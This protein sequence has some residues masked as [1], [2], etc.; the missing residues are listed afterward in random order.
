MDSDST[1]PKGDEYSDDMQN[2]IVM[3]N[4]VDSQKENYFC[5]NCKKELSADH[6]KENNV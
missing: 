2:R 6:F 1:V 3:S 4:E 5:S